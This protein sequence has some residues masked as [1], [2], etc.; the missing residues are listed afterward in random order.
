MFEKIDKVAKQLRLSDKDI[1]LL[2]QVTQA[3]VYRYRKDPPTKF[4]DNQRLIRASKALKRLI[5]MQI[6]LSTMT[7][8]QRARAVMDALE[9]VDGDG[10]T[11]GI[12]GRI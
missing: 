10:L 1:A 7:P 3:M 11:I 2:L 12:E 8:V 5:P 6:E 9:G 4:K